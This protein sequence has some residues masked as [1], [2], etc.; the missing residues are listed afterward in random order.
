MTKPSNY[1][2]K[3]ANSPYSALLIKRAVKTFCASAES[4]ILTGKEICNWSVLSVDP[5]APP[6]PKTVTASA[7]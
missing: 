5:G 2:I 7:G 6:I 3:K 4:V 1:R